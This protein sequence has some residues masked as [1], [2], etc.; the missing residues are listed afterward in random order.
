[1]RIASKNCIESD[2]V[3]EF[4]LSN[5]YLT[6]KIK[7][8]DIKGIYGSDNGKYIDW[9]SFSDEFQRVLYYPN[10]VHFGDKVSIILPLKPV[11]AISIKDKMK[12]QIKISFQKQI[13]IPVIEKI[14]STKEEYKLVKNKNE[15]KVLGDRK[16]ISII[17]ENAKFEMKR[18]NDI[19]SFDIIPNDIGSIIIYFLDQRPSLQEIE[20]EYNGYLNYLSEFF[21][22]EN[23]LINSLF[24]F[25]L[26]TAISN[27]KKGIENDFSALYA[28]PNYSLP[29]RT[30]YRDS[31]WTAKA[32]LPFEPS[33]VKDQIKALS[34]GI[35]EKGNA[36][37]GIIFA[38]KEEFELSKEFAI[39]N[40]AIFE[41]QKKPQDWWSD[42]WDSPYYFVLL[43]YDYLRWTGDFEILD[44][45][46]QMKINKILSR[47]EES[48]WLFFK[49]EDVKDWSDNVVRSGFVT[50]D[51]ALYAGALRTFSEVL[52]LKGDK[53]LADKYMSGYINIKDFLNSKMWIKDHFIDYKNDKTKKVEEHLNIDTAV[54]LLYQIP[55]LEDIFINKIK[56]ELFTKNN[57][58]QKFGDWGIMSVWPFYKYREDLKFKSAFPYRYHNGSDWPYWDG[59]IAKILLDKSDPDWMYPLLRSWKYSLSKGW[60]LPVEYYSPPFGRGGLLQAWSS[61]FTWAIVSGGFGIEP[62]INGNYSPKTPQWG[63]S[64][65]KFRFRN[66]IIAIG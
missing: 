57:N 34:I 29:A 46:I 65:L 12:I 62:D 47:F 16:K 64:S 3:N 58:N 20:N 40:P 53:L 1:M 55:Y 33:I 6:V 45:E 54:T 31:F 5:K 66:E 38:S 14:L 44:Q 56:K 39:S 30:Y 27:H 59:I 2:L 63:R 21:N 49:D 11:L 50:Y 26:H 17:V 51:L 43:I 13:R 37:S 48:N 41:F 7:N 32:L 28:G 10:S 52:N 60:Y 22:S 42:H 8:S 4:Y 35:D 24:I 23:E 18:S 25:S 36:P 19:L 9:I 15:I 61:V